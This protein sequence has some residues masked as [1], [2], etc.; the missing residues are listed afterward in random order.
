[1]LFVCSKANKKL[2]KLIPLAEVHS[3]RALFH[4]FPI[5]KTRLLKYIE[6]FTTKN[7]KFSAKNL[8]FFCFFFFIF[9]LKTYIMGTR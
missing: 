6:N 1:M 3:V 9:L 7:W 2:Q 8:M 5:T 4:F